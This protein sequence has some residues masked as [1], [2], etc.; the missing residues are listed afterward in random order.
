M[1]IKKFIALVILY[2]CSIV[3]FEPA[4]A[5]QNLPP[6]NRSSLSVQQ[7]WMVKG[8]GWL[9]GCGSL[10]LYRGPLGSLFEMA[11]SAVDRMRKLG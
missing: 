10:F 8:G 4:W 6:C 11:V 1:S 5:Q 7:I 9:G 3:S 2:L